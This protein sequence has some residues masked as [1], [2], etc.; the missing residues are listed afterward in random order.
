MTAF[1]ID[2]GTTNSVIA[3][4]VSG[5]PEAIPIDGSA[6]VPSVV[7]YEE[8][9]VVVGREA[10]NLELQHPERTLRSVKRHMGSAH[11]WQVGGRNVRAESASAEI[12]GRLRR[13]AEEATGETVRDVVITVPAYFDEGQRRATLKAGEQAGLNVLRLLNEPTAAS[14]VYD[15]LGSDGAPPDEPQLVLVYDLGGGT[16]DVSILEVFNDIREV[17]ATAGNT[18]LGGDDFDAA[19]VQRFLVA[20]RIQGVDVREDPVAMARLRRVAEQ[21][22]IQLSTETSVLVREEFLTT[23]EGVAIH[24]EVT[25]TRRELEDLIEELLA[26]TVALAE[27]AIADAGIEAEDL[28]QICLVGGSTRIPRVRELLE[29]AF[30]VEVHEE[31]DPDLAVA[32]GA[33]IQAAVLAG[34]PV[35]R[36]LVD[37]TS[38]SL[39]VCVLGADDDLHADTFAPI[40][41]RNTVL[42][43]TRSEEFYTAVHHQPSVLVSVYQGESARAS[44]NTLVGEFSFPLEP[45]PDGTPVAC[46]FTYTLDG[47]IEVRVEQVGGK[48][49]EKTLNVADKAVGGT[50]A[51]VSSSSGAE[52]QSAVERQ[53]ERLLS[54]LEGAPHE[55][56]AKLLAEY[57]ASTVEARESAEEA[58]LD[59][60]L[61]HE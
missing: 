61:D 51:K 10:H 44:E 13:G 29:A 56:L 55:N 28:S 35:D 25:V 38:H 3:R 4:L 57:R 22:K 37:V 12:L 45:C 21:T 11:E 6:I 48:R 46:A 9:R 43:T 15:H 26:S 40:I 20:L 2:L 27:K 41:R 1:G 32:L 50:K 30:H 53:A 31:I 17:R 34:E 23:H 19:L 49:V 47:T 8:D 52:P 7:L 24:L 33:A 18:R 16:F 5:R 58:L 42:P 36:I 39:G 60:F 54:T 14:L 59:F